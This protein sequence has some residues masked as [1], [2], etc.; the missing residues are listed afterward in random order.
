MYM[1]VLNLNRRIALAF[2][3]GSWYV[4]KYAG[5]GVSQQDILWYARALA[6]K[7]YKCHIYLL[8]LIYH[9]EQAW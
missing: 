5:K 6:N 8:S 3:L 1:A 2:F 4:M 7:R 9:Q